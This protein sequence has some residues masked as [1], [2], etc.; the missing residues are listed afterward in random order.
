M[1]H[2]P[3]KILLIE[4]NPGDVHLIQGMLGE[5]NGIQFQMECAG[6]LDAGLKKLAEGGINLVL[7]DLGLPDSQGLD[8]VLKVHNQS[9]DVPIV[10]LTVFEDDNLG[11]NAVK[12]GVQDYLVKGQVS[13]NLLIRS[14]RYSIERKQAEEQIKES[15]K[16]KE[17]LLNEIHHRV[18]NN[19]QLISSLLRLQSKN[20]KDNKILDIFRAN[21]NRIRSMALIHEKLYK[22]KDLIRIDFSDFIGKLTAPLLSIYRN[23]MQD[24][25]LKLEVE[26]IFLDVN[27]AI[28]C[29]L[30]IN[31]LVSNS[32]KH[33]FRGRKKGEIRVK[34]EVDEEDEYTLIVSD[35]GNGLPEG[36]D[37]RKTETLGLQLVMDLTSQLD[38]KIELGRGKGAEFN[39]VF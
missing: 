1:N 25:D 13:S 12:E 4:D 22:S 38:G 3:T 32:L 35:T 6:R 26:D 10:V 33:A 11:C 16:Q 8:T 23:E 24:I 20:I 34:M 17:I 28:H 27:K 30:I 29:A 21:Q 36:F 15:L 9:P 19:L 14:I 7:L 18:K 5:A 37:F 2:N 39:I 31:E